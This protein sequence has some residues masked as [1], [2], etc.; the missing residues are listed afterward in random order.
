MREDHAYRIPG[1]W[2]RNRTELRWAVVRHAERAD[3]S[4]ESI[5]DLDLED[6]RFPADPPITR[7]GLQTARSLGD[8][9]AES[10]K[11]NVVITSPYLRCVQTAVEICLATHCDMIIDAGWGEVGHLGGDTRTLSELVKYAGDRGVGVRN[12]AELLGSLPTAEETE[13][14]AHGRYMK[15]ALTYLDRARR[16]H[17]NFIVVTHAGAL[18]SCSQLFAETSRA[19]IQQVGFCSY[20]LGGLRIQRVA[21]EE[22][23]CSNYLRKQVSFLGADNITMLPGALSY[24]TPRYVRR[25]PFLRKRD[26]SSDSHGSNGSAEDMV[27][28]NSPIMSPKSARKGDMLPPPRLEPADDN[29]S[30]RSSDVGSLDVGQSSEEDEADETKPAQDQKLTQPKLVLRSK[31]FL[32]RSESLKSAPGA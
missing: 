4:Y 3:V 5:E 7:N 20:L 15:S 27:F 16:A 13:R 32:R 19:V 8:D 11:W 30:G 26:A 29:E 14:S 25:N 24:E 31:L 6:F 22:A 2:H 1:T 23:I 28:G 9:F 21:P 17:M 18:L 12:P 10:E